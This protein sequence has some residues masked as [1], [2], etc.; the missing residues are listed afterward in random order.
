MLARRQ[1]PAIAAPAPA[2]R[3]REFAIARVA[4]RDSAV[5]IRANKV[6]L[7]GAI[8]SF[9]RSDHDLLSCRRFAKKPLPIDDSMSNRATAR[10]AA[11]YT[12]AVVVLCLPALW[13][14]FPLMFDTVGGCL[15]SWK[16]GRLAFV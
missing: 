11:A 4:P 15:E 7:P 16:N 3:S 1:M 9:S 13:N 12:V 2:S 6:D 8:K 5:A 10:H 14:G